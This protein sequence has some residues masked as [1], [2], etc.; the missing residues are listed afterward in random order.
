M[1]SPARPPT[2]LVPASVRT[3]DGRVARS[4]FGTWDDDV[5]RAACPAW[6]THRC[7][8]R[9]PRPPFATLQACRCI[10]TG[11]PKRAD[12]TTPTASTEHRNDRRVRVT[13]EQGRGRQVPCSAGH[14]APH[15]LG[16]AG[17]TSRASCRHRAASRVAG[18]AQLR[19]RD[20][21]GARGG[22]QGPEPEMLVEAFGALVDRVD[23]DGADRELLRGE[24]DPS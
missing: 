22:A 10:R 2:K 20:H 12:S 6:R 21:Q 7:R 19:E 18:G 3:I 16:G 4:A 9:T 14:C 24:R 13:A 23:H 11:D 5:V 17:R 1:R 15:A 8:P